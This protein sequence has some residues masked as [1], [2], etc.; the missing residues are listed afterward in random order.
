[1]LEKIRAM[2]VDVVTCDALSL[3]L[4]A[5]NAKAVNL[6]LLGLAAA[7]LGL[8]AEPWIAVIEETVPP[9]TVEVNLR[10]FRLGYGLVRTL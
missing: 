7:K 9:K 8:E 4:E 5:G 6:V 2:G 1:M 10:A 3:A